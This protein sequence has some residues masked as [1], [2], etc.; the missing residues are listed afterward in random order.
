[1][2]KALKLVPEGKI[3]WLNINEKYMRMCIHTKKY[4][5]AYDVYIKIISN[6]GLK[7]V[8]KE[9]KKDSNYEHEEFVFKDGQ[10]LYLKSDNNRLVIPWSNSASAPR[11]LQAV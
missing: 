8:Y 5:N 9:F 4:Q 1:M 3:S 10:L 6:Y 7:S 2:H 11:R